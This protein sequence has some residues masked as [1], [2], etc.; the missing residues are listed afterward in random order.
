MGSILSLLVGPGKSIIDGVSG[1]ISKFTASPEEKLQ[2]QQ[3]LLQMEKEY[4]EACMAADTQFAIQ[5]AAGITSEAKSDSVLARNW[6]PI[7]ML[8]FTVIVAFN[9]IVAPLFSLHFL[10]IPPDMW[11]LLKLGITGYIVGRSAEK[12]APTIITAMKS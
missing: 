6:R 4:Q 2:A 12:V 10:P 9:Y 3:A 7:L 5:Q 1:L 8:T 11:A